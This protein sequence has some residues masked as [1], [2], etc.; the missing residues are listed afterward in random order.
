MNYSKCLYSKSLYLAVVLLIAMGPVFGQNEMM[1]VFN[2]GYLETVPLITDSMYVQD[3]FAKGNHKDRFIGFLYDGSDRLTTVREKIVRL[4]TK[5]T[6]FYNKTISYTAD[7]RI[8][9][10]KR[11]DQTGKTFQYIRTTYQQRKDGQTSLILVLSSTDGTNWI[12]SQKVDILYNTRGQITTRINHLWNNVSNQWYED[13]QDRY[14]YDSKGD[15]KTV[16]YELKE[17]D[18]YQVINERRYEYNG[19]KSTI[20]VLLSIQTGG[21]LVKVDSTFKDYKGDNAADTVKVYGWNNVNKQWFL[22][23]IEL[24][25][26]KEQKKT[27]RGSIQKTD[28]SG[29]LDKSRETVYSAGLGKY[30]DE[31][32]EIAERIWDKTKK[33]WKEIFKTEITYDDISTGKVRGKLR[34]TV[35]ADPK[36]PATDL[37]LEVYAWMRTKKAGF[38]SDSTEIAK[39][40]LP[41]SCNVRSPYVS[42]QVVNFPPSKEG[43]T[44]MRQLQIHSLEGRLVHTQNIGA[45]GEGYLDASLPPGLYI[46]SIHQADQPLCIQKLIVE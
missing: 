2:P 9:T 35:T 42:H 11:S 26:D 25:N 44:A 3:R 16:V 22:K 5:I 32:M 27:M 31:P 24:L 37:N 8:E 34:R 45:D 43:S 29:K 38:R 23:Y 41:G 4:D 10:H 14:E 40:S 21:E 1:R 39:P 28:G 13:Q 17:K 7:G 19:K 36:E 46:V 33:E 15:L 6:E 20:E 12:N 18:Q 30:T